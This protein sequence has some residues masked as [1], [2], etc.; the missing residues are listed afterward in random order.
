MAVLDPRKVLPDPRSAVRSHR[1]PWT[2]W[3]FAWLFLNICIL[4]FHNWAPKEHLCWS[5]CIVTYIRER[6]RETEAV[7]TERHAD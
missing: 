7:T 4:S 5:L 2:S 1:L 6:G 3:G